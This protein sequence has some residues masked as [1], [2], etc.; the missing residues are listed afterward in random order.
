MARHVGINGVY[1]KLGKGNTM[2][3]MVKPGWKLEAASSSFPCSS[4]A[5]KTCD[6]LREGANKEIPT[7]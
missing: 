4:G 1:Y 6:N 7:Q 5:F 3:K 2:G